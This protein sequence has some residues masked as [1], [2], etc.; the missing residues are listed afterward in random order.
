MII[1][2]SIVITLGIMI[3]VGMALIVVG[4]VFRAILFGSDDRK[5]NESYFN[6]KDDNND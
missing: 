6:R 3:L 1:L 2:E 5:F 4:T